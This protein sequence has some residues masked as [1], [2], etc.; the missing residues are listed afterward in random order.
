MKKFLIILLVSVLALIIAFFIGTSLAS[1]ALPQG[2]KGAQADSLAKKMLYAI[3]NN[4]WGNT[5]FVAW[6]FSDRHSFIWDKDSHFV[7]VKWSDKHAVIDLNKQTG[8]AFKDDELITDIDEKN[9]IIAKGI[10]HFNNDSFWL[11]AP[12][13]VF[14]SGTERRLVN[15]EGQKALLVTYTSGG[16][17]PGDS[18]LWI[19]NDNGLPESYKMWVSIIPVKGISASWE[20][21]ESLST[22]AKIAT[23]HKISF[24][25]IRIKDLK[26]AETLTEISPDTPDLFSSLKK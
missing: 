26:S 5:K 12:A 22:G 2:E 16:T 3:D 25:N 19:L 10:K 21:W 11:N 20:D 7:S 23:S 4:A 8:I 6:N 14:D 15:Y 24:L 1:E 17:T 13:K 9:A 18:Y